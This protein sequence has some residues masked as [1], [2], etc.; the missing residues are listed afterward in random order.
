[1]SL[2][3]GGLKPRIEVLAGLVSSVALLL[4]ADGAASLSS[5]GRSSVHT[6]GPG[7]SV[8]SDFLFF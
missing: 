5:R 6:G 7:A 3:S 8:Y 1:M 2:S 4:L